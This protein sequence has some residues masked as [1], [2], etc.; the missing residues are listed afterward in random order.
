MKIKKLFLLLTPAVLSTPIFALSCEKNNQNFLPKL[1]DNNKINLNDDK[2]RKDSE[3]EKS[4]K[5]S[6][7]LTNEN[8]NENPKNLNKENKNDEVT[9]LNKETSN[10]ESPNSENNVSSVNSEIN[11]RN[12][13]SNENFNSNEPIKLFDKSFKINE[14][15]IYTNP[16]FFKVEPSEAEEPGFNYGT[17]PL[18]KKKTRALKVDDLVDMFNYIVGNNIL[19][20]YTFGNRNIPS[21]LMAQAY[22]KWVDENWV[23][24]P[25]FSF[26][27]GTITFART[28]NEQFVTR[29]YTAKYTSDFRAINSAFQK[30]RD[31][32]KNGLN[33]IKEGMT[34]YEKAYAL[35]LYVLEFFRYDLANLVATVEEDILKQQAVC[36]VYSTV[37]GYLLNLA[38]L[39]SLTNMAGRSKQGMVHAVTYVKLQLPG[40]RMAKWY[41]TDPTWGDGLEGGEMP[42]D[43]YPSMSNEIDFVEFLSPIGK[44]FSEAIMPVQFGFGQFWQLNYDDFQTTE[45]FYGPAKK[46]EFDNH[47]IYSNMLGNPSKYKSR[48]RYEFYNKEWYTLVKDQNNKNKLFKRPFYS[49]SQDQD[50]ALVNVTLNSLFNN[51]N[52]DVVA[53][54]ENANGEPM[55]A[56]INNNLI[57]YGKENGKKAFFAIKNMKSSNTLKV[58][59]PDT[60]NKEITRYFVKNDNIYYQL[61][62]G[63][64]ILELKL[65]ENQRKFIFEK[66]DITYFDLDKLVSELKNNINMLIVGNQI[67][68]IPY[69]KEKKIFLTT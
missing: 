3:V 62:K 51:S 68:Q 2:V 31:F 42:I 24:F 15:G 25:Y 50:S 14:N 55:L 11:E 63:T 7:K 1:I 23:Y 59:V 35:W 41:L 49:E 30:Y 29:M 21:D 37:Y 64:P 36:A 47:T 52:S 10:Q 13:T 12:N 6:E 9:N 45:W 67:G 8:K 53:G 34:D 65:D 18:I 46:I 20:D 48:S 61:G 43:D 69:L 39:H 33:K 58:E 4:K 54:I 26:G 57:F 66:E 40:E 38:G 17:A 22:I 16:A 5:D 28:P 27:S 60:E 32:I 44:S 56:S 19:S